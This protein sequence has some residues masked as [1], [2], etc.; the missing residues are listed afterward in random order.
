MCLINSKKKIREKQAAVQI[1]R[2][3]R[4]S[5]SLN[6]DR[7]SYSQLLNDDS[8]WEHTTSQ[9]TRMTSCDVV[10]ICLAKKSFSSKI[11]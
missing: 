1:N 9:Y 7:I 2:G 4:I 5:L 11:L 6:N 8:F 10:N 3:F